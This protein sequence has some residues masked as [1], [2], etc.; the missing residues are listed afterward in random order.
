MPWVE[1]SFNAVFFETY[2]AYLKKSTTEAGKGYVLIDSTGLPNDM[3][4]PITAV[5]NHNGE[6]NNEVRLIYVV[7]RGT[8]MQ[9]YMRYIPGNIV[10]VMNP[11]LLPKRDVSTNEK[12]LTF[13][14]N[15]I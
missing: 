9:I 5:S 13:S 7:Q 10:N 11:A 8:G 12:I 6:I 14:L 15:G 3:R 2:I 4:L 1:K